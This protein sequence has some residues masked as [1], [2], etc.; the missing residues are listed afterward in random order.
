MQCCNNMKQIGIGMLTFE[1]QKNR[2]PRQYGR[3]E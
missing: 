3:M 1:N 2:L